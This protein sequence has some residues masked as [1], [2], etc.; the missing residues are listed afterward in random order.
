MNNIPALPSIEGDLLLDVLT[1]QSHRSCSSPPDSTEHGG[2]ERLAELGHTVL[3]MTIMYTLF[4][5]TPLVSAVDLSERHKE[6]MDDAHIKHWL[7]CYNL[8]SRV[9][10][11][12]DRSRLDDPVEERL[13]FSS[14]V[15]AVYI[16]KGL[17]PLIA[18]LSRLVNPESEPLAVPGSNVG[19]TAPPPPPYSTAP[20]PPSVPPP[21][22]PMLSPPP[23]TGTPTVNTLALFNQTCSQRGL[24]INWESESE[25]PAHQPRWA[26]KCY[27]NNQLKGNGTGR[28]QKMAKEEAARQAFQ[29]LGWGS[30][31]I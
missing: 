13:L 29:A 28:N 3:N 20:A 17:P 2:A 27:V 23:P 10:G 14:Y 8:K 11:V 4:Q 30:E 22:P 21:P 16:Q 7:T 9:R 31:R 15:G 25:G 26:V 24:V 18:W 19:A 5:R 6:L 12:E 1:R